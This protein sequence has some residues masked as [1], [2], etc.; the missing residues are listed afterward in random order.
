MFNEFRL[1]EDEDMENYVKDAIK[2]LKE[3]DNIVFINA[4]NVTL[5]G[6]IH[7]QYEYQRIM[8]RKEFEQGNSTSKDHVM[9]QLGDCLDRGPQNL[10]SFV[11]TL[12]WKLVY[13]KNFYFIRGNHE[14]LSMTRKY[15]AEKEITMKYSTVMYNRLMECCKYIPIAAVVNSK[16]WCVHG[17]IPYF[18]KDDP[19][20]IET[21][22]EDRKLRFSEPRFMPIEM[23]NILWS[24]PVS[25]F[26]EKPDRCFQSS[27]RGSNIYD[28]TSLGTRKFLEKNRLKEIIRGHEYYDKGYKVFKNHENATVVRSIF[29]SPNYCNKQNNPG[30]VM[31]IRGNHK[32]ISTYSPTTSGVELPPSTSLWEFILPPAMKLYLEFGVRV[33]EYRHRLPE[34]FKT[35]DKDGNGKLDANEILQGLNLKSDKTVMRMIKVHDTDGDGVISLEELKNMCINFSRDRE[36]ILFMFFDDDLDKRIS[37]KDLVKSVKRINSSVKLPKY[38]FDKG[39][40]EVLAFQSI[41]LLTNKNF[42]SYEDFDKV[43]SILGYKKD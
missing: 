31:Q 23:Q 15:G 29:S 9:V 12:A 33:L 34:L 8:Y 26:D 6:D 39:V 37:V 32:Q 1:P 11:Y 38:W 13:P 25:N 3:E 35:L 17:G 16:Y 2:I 18:Q 4:T 20:K 21:L 42:V 40:L 27:N 10:E 43:F 7:G 30:T 36:S 22:N 41:H 24:D 19:P 28:F 14:S 5:F